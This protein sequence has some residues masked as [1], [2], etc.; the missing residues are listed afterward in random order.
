MGR[1]I[2]RDQKVKEQEEIKR[3][4]RLRQQEL[5]KLRKFEELENKN[6]NPN[7]NI[8]LQKFDIDKT[9]EN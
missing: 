5:D 3:D 6:N 8:G 4:Q 1:R 2:D 9:S 7:P